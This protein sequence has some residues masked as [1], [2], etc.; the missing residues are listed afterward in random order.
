M[1]ST[2]KLARSRDFSFLERI[3][4]LPSG[5][6]AKWIMLVLWL[7]VMAIT[8]PFAG[9]LPQIENNNAIAYLPSSAPS[10]KVNNALANFPGG[11]QVPGVVVYVARSGTVTASDLALV[12][13]QQAE[14][15]KKIVSFKPQATQVSSDHK[16]IAYNFAINQPDATKLANDVESLRKIIA[17]GPELSSYVT[18]A[19]GLL[20]D[21]ANAFQGIDGILLIVT[22][23]VVVVLLLLIYRSPFLWLVPLLSVVG[24]IGLSDWAVYQLA[25]HAGVI[26][27][28]ETGGILT[29]LVFGAGT[30]YALLLTARYRE[31]LRRF[32]DH[33]DAMHMALRRA[34]P[35]IL[36]SASTVILALLCLLAAELN[37]ESG[38]GPIGAVGIASALLAQLTFLP[39]MLTIFGRRLFWPAK[40]QF[41]TQASE[42]EGLWAKVAKS[43]SRH[44]RSIWTVTAAALLV[45]SMGLS[46]LHLGLQPGQAFVNNPQSVT[47]QQIYAQHFPAG[48]SEPL[49]V[50]ANASETASVLR[51]VQAVP[52]VAKALPVATASG[53]VEILAILAFEPNSSESYSTVRTMRA[54]LAKIPD[55]NAL[56]GGNI[57]TTLDTNNAATTDRYIVVPLVLLIV[58]LVLGILLRAIVAPLLLAITVVLS[59]A[60]A[61]GVSSLVFHALG[62]AGVDQSIPLLAFIFLVALGVDYNIF[63]VSRIREET[64]QLGTRKGTEFGVRLTGGVITSAGIVLAATFSVLAVLPLVAL[65]EIGFIVAFGVLLDTLV[66]RSLLVPALITDLDKRFWWPSSLSNHT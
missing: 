57:A 41:Q 10:T 62:F 26:V 50:I 45:L 21:T 11:Q 38:L 35:A 58:M 3:V 56:V 59:F 7:A 17:G 25:L 40:P 16:A 61:L 29:V 60:A 4:T 27:S 30:D 20:A 22:G 2:S 15:T 39:A 46:Q 23:L 52:G 49:I 5:R 8:G 1:V 13:R 9:K 28:G 64:H 12:A 32:E 48:G 65:V 24:A 66:V 54:E 14:A 18:G 43:I 31:E 37:S 51:T 53:K 33:H 47:G 36:A 55:A 6:R 63:L 34:S 19:A 42:V 44:P